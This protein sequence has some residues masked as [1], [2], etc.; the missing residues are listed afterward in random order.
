MNTPAPVAPPG[1]FRFSSKPDPQN[2]MNRRH[3][4]FA[5]AAIPVALP[6]TLRAA[7]APTPSTQQ[8]EDRLAALERRSGGRLGVAAADAD[9]KMTIGHRADER[10]AVC[11]TFKVVLAGAIL[12]HSGDIDG[13]LQRR[14]RYRRSELVA[15]SPVSSQHVDDGMTVAAL[16]AA[17]IQYSDNTAANLLMK[18]LGGP[19]A[20][21]AYAHSIGNA[22]FR[23]DR[24]EPA[25][26]SC[27][28]DDPRD[29]ATPAA[30]AASL[31][32]LALGDALSP[33]HRAQLNDWLRGNTTGAKRI[34]AAVPAGW[35]VG[36]KTGSG[37]YGTANDLAVLYPPQ[38]KPIVLAVYYTRDE[39]HAPWRDDVI[40][41]AAGVVVEG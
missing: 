20:V 12:A 8:I 24:W 40:A 15:N 19:Q 30:M 14:I 38:R 5:T 34:R 17:A 11:S 31:R 7:G 2:P 4:L 37:D 27:I 39:P 3:F 22:A 1:S 13:G 28:P 6:F 23:L 26:N 29:T 32:T 10:F 36:D 41:A 18:L 9:G 21:T 35:N 16:C 25:L 33:E